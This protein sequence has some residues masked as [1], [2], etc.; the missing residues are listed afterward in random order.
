[1]KDEKNCTVTIEVEQSPSEVFRCITDVS[2]WWGGPD[3]SGSTSKLNDEFVVN[4]AGAHYSK[5]RVVEFVPDKK[6]AWLVTESKLD[7]IERNKGDWTDTK[8]IFELTST[9]SKTTLRFTHQGLTPLKESFEKCSKGWKLI[10]EDYLFNF[11]SLNKAHFQFN[12]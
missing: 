4:H 2:K 12:L 6:I 1:M 11:I 8:M 5:Q 7:W 3:L 9:G 10:I